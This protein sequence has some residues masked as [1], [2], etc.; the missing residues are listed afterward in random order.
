MMLCSG[1]R[2]SLRVQ[3]L[4]LDIEGMQPF[5]RCGGEFALARAA[6]PFFESGPL[7]DDHSRRADHG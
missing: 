1:W 7:V 4:L 3:H 5:P 6:L 2:S